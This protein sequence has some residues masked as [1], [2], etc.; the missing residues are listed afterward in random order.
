MNFKNNKFLLIILII[1][2]VIA[3]SETQTVESWLSKQTLIRTYDDGA[4]GFGNQSAT[5]N[6]IN[7]IRQLGFNGTFE[8]IY[9]TKPN[10]IAVLFNLPKNL[11]EDYLDQRRNIRFITYKK[12][13]DLMIAH[14]LP[15]TTLAFVGGGGD[16][17]WN[18]EMEGI[19]V[20]SDW[21]EEE[22]PYNN[23]AYMLNT[24]VA[25]RISPWLSG[26]CA[27][28]STIYLPDQKTPLNDCESTKKFVV[29]PVATFTQAKD[30]LQFDLDGKR[31]LQEKPALKTL[32]DVMENQSKN[33]WPLYGQ[34]L[35]QNWND[36]D[37]DK[38][39]ARVMLGVI[40]A[41]RYAEVHDSELQKPLIIPV[42][43]DITREAKELFDLINDKNWDQYQFPGK[44]K[45]R[46]AL[47]DL[48]VA[49]Y[50]EI[51]NLTDPDAANKILNLKNG[52]I[53]LLS[54]GSLPKVV[55]DAIY[56]YDATNVWPQIREGENT[57]NTLL[58]TGRPH[59]RVSMPSETNWEPT[60]VGFGPNVF[61]K[62]KQLDEKFNHFIFPGEKFWA[63]LQP[64]VTLGNYIIDAQDHSSLLSQY[65]AWLK[66][67]A[68]KKENDRIYYLL[69]QGMK[70]SGREV[71]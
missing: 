29:T 52:H 15:L 59:I 25:V 66:K 13:Y 62:S 49:D 69:E 28:N 50:F 17:V 33:I 9:L 19:D 43:Y 21:N 48:N 71:R 58:L 68:L 51:A 65:F 56:N 1:L 61:D 7:R 12:Y 39:Y 23:D 38:P 70:Q 34:T 6:A 3:F 40:A 64:E 63:D 4:P 18:L 41:A 16:L 46:A 60:D 54:V 32:M 37:P 42:F 35:H 20:G 24:K 30:Y 22:Y 27:P 5:I 11:P 44:E 10:K 53:L 47:H 14:N 8:Y 26:N 36:P 45:A 55:F 2:P 67:E 31:L 57:F